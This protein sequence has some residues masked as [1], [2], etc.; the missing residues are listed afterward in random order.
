MAP[1]SSPE[2]AP[3]R[4]GIVP[5]AGKLLLL[6]VIA[7]FEL[8]VLVWMAHPRIT[9][10][11]RRH[12]VD[13]TSACWSPPGYDHVVARRPQ[14]STIIPTRLDEA[15]SCVYFPDG[16]GIGDPDGIWTIAHRARI[17]LPVS[18]DRR[19]IS[20]W[21]VAPGYLP[22]AQAFSIRQSGSLIAAGR[23]DPHKSGRFDFTPDVAA[24]DRDGFDTLEL[25][26]ARPARP[27]D[28]HWRR[29]DKRLLGLLLTRVE[30]SRSSGAVSSHIGGRVG[31][32]AGTAPAKLT[33]TLGNLGGA[34]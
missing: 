17:R 9:D 28:L 4:P 22:F 25:A 15:T 23:V 1:I 12:F 2:A 11:Y 24:A 27:R 30:I 26:I 16:W 32:R 19:R 18:S 33:K 29:N 14:P 13:L 6:G 3:S 7:G 20:L 10:A 21:F 31:E 5:L 8:I 34:P